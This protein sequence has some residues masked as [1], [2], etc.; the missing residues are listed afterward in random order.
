[1]LAE[2]QANDDHVDSAV[3]GFTLRRMGRVLFVTQSI[4]SSARACGV[5]SRE[6]ESDVE[7]TVSRSR[8][9]F[10]LCNSECRTERR[11]SGDRIVMCLRQRPAV[12]VAR[13]EPGGSQGHVRALQ[14]VAHHA[15]ASAMARRFTASTRGSFDSSCG[16]LE[17]LQSR[18]ISLRKP[19]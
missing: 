14:H 5:L 15:C 19:T 12:S 1:M 11:S 10:G 18:S 9:P 17:N 4:L 7:A 2:H 13:D 16:E 3:T 6:F 8:K